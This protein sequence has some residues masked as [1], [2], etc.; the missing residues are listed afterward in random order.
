MDAPTAPASQ[1]SQMRNIWKWAVEGRAGRGLPPLLLLI[2]VAA[3]A[4]RLYGINWDQGNFF[5]PDERSIYMRVDCMYRLLTKAASYRECTTDAPFQRVVAGIPNPAVFLDAAK[6]PLN[7]HWFPLG[8]MV[9]Y[10]L[11]AIKLLLAP[12]MSMDLH[13]LAIAGR[14]LS[15]M[16]DVGTVALVY[17]LGRRLYGRGAGLLAAALV[18]FAVAHIQHSHYYRPETF[19]NL[20]VLASFLSMLNVTEKKRLRDSLWLGLFVGLA[21]ATKVSV[22]P[23]LLPLAVV[24]G[25]L[26]WLAVHNGDTGAKAEQ[27][28]RVALR[29]LAAGA[30]AAATYLFWTPYALLDFP[31]FLVWNL[32][33]LD[34]V[35]HAGIVP[36]TVQYIGAPKFLYE[37]GQTTF[38]GMGVPLGLMAW[39]GLLAT[40]VL[41]LR[42]PRL[43]QVLLLLW[44]APLLLTVGSVEVKFLRYTFPLIPFLILMGSGAAWA[45]MR[46]M[47]KRRKAL[48]MAAAVAIGLVLAST[49]FYALAFQVIYSRPHTAV[50]ASVWINANVPFGTHILTDNHWDEGIPDMGRYSLTQLPM[51]E[52]DTPQKMGF[53]ASDLASAEYL[54]FYS[55]RT[56][57]AIARVPERYP[58]S[59]NY[60]RLLFSGELGYELANSFSSYPRLLG[61]AFVDD[62]FGR[63]GVPAP[64]GLASES[65]APLSL[66]LGYADN[67]AITYDHPL[68]MVFKN[69]A[70]YDA[71]RL[72]AI[73]LK[74][75]VTVEP[76]PALMLTPDELALQQQ[77]GTWSELFNGDSLANRY[78]VLVWLLLVETVFLATLP[79]GFV[80]FRGLSDRGY[81]LTKTLAVLLLAYI[82][83]LLAGVK[84]MDFGRLSIYLTLAGLA[85]ASTVIVVLRRRDIVAF[86]RGHWRILALEEAL[87][88][89]AFLAFVAVRWANPDLWHPYRGGEKPMDLAYLIAVVRSTTVPPYDPWFAGGYLNYYYF[90]QFIVAT[91]IKATGILPEVAYNLAVPLLFA[92]TAGGAFSV[93]Y[94]LTSALRQRGG[95]R[96]GPDWGPAAAGVV[97]VL[98]VAVL[99]NLGSAVELVRTVWSHVASTQAPEGDPFHVWFWFSSRMM[100]GQ[101][102][103]TEFPAWTFL[104]ADLHAH[105]IAIPF[106]LLAVG[107]SLNLVLAAEEWGL[108]WSALALP[109]VVLAL[110]VG[111]LAAINTWDYPTYLLLALAAVLLA[112]YVVR[113][114]LDMRLLSPAALGAVTMAGLSYIAFLPFHQ[115]YVGSNLGVHGSAEQTSLPS[116]LAVHGLFLFLAVSYLVWEAAGHLRTAFRRSHATDVPPLGLLSQAR[117][118]LLDSP[119]LPVA[120]P[121]A[122]ALVA[123]MSAAGYATVAL[124]LVVA[125]VAV[126]L[127]VR[128]F[129][130]GGVQATYHLFLLV[131]LVGAFGLGMAVDLVTLN[132]DIDR[133]NTVFKLYLQDWVL[134]AVASAT[135][136]W[137]LVASGRN[138]IRKLLWAKSLW[139][140]LLLVLVAGVSVFPVMGARVR[141]RERFSTAFTGLNGAQ[142]MDTAVYYDEHGPINLHWDWAAIQWLRDNVK[143]SPVVAE[144]NAYPSQYRWGSR[145]SIYTGL[146]TIVGW[147]WHQTQQRAGEEW[148]VQRRLG[149]LAALYNTTDMGQAQKILRDYGVKYVYVGEL[150]RL[151]YSKEGLAKFPRM[152]DRGLTLVYTNPDVDIYQVNLAPESQGI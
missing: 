72:A 148:A 10:V 66:R 41:N 129:M 75:T 92:L 12:I 150:E 29:A 98:L 63:A 61:V 113:R 9:I 105:L 121:A 6:S 85:L 55:N 87:F 130:E 2:L 151:Y 59:S 136:L 62:P 94:N 82:P 83:W 131:L 16:A 100:P 135:I 31:E 37:L 101:N 21:F 3:L 22:L 64:K 108:R 144:G 124:L 116:Y 54:V 125:L 52:G 67:D 122:A 118:T 35:R 68:V 106:A 80:V 45:G 93:V 42:R 138:S 102:S 47:E 117:G 84:L 133:M 78:P 111:S 127:A 40:A 104:F 89:V 13:D 50:Q 1:P 53:V 110:A 74:P 44:V 14:T 73:L 88:L 96:L 43:G 28:E 134:Y 103:I 97:A 36:Y 99:G 17:I 109:L 128:H 5:H 20:F 146:P 143:G 79:L 34:I 81:L 139:L 56:Y 8:S 147:G 26:L 119:L 69:T 57:G 145:V 58:L 77:G 140:L 126:M 114:R 38:W 132:N 32:R 27:A 112:A 39:G 49:A 4:L 7:P 123:Y 115:R 137:Y 46:W 71:N 107:L 24:Y 152:A 149:D 19:T 15:A 70:R 60:Y 90:G 51:F 23:L 11:L 86:V 65:P 48:G 120:L 33:E 76:K 141:L 95:F 25:R 142:Y 91:L 30:V 18:A